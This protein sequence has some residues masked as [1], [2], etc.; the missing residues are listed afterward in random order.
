MALGFYRLDPRHLEVVPCGEIGP[1]LRRRLLVAVAT[2]ARARFPRVWAG[3]TR[4]Y[5]R[6]ASFS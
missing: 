4:V 5:G 1:W 3:V 6:C 2:A